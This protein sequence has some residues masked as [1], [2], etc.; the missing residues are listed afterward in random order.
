M[1]FRWFLH[2]VVGAERGSTPR[3]TACGETDA[4]T[5]GRW[6]FLEQQ[7]IARQNRKTGKTSLFTMS[8][9]V[10]LEHPCCLDRAGRARI[11]TLCRMKGRQ[12]RQSSIVLQSE[13][14]RCQ[15]FFCPQLSFFILGYHKNSRMDIAIQH[16]LAAFFVA[17]IS[18]F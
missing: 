12:L 15:F 10:C 9:R 3:A 6:A 4:R 14:I 13:G 1:G 5:R 17:S 16:C 2:D 18:T 7:R 11:N 8:A